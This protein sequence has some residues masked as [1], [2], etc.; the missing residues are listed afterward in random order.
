MPACGLNAHLNARRGNM[1][2]CRTVETMEEHQQPD[3]PEPFQNDR[4]DLVKTVM[5][6][7]AAAAGALLVVHAM[8]APG[9]SWWS[10]E[11]WTTP[12][13]GWV[14]HLL[15]YGTPVEVAIYAAAFSVVVAVIV[16][17]FTKT[18]AGFEMWL[19]SCLVVVCAMAARFAAT[20]GLENFD[21]QTG[22]WG[23]M[24]GSGL[25]D[26]VA[27]FWAGEGVSLTRFAVLTTGTL[28]F[29]LGA[30][31]TIVVLVGVKNM[32]RQ[33]RAESSDHPEKHR[34]STD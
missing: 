2:G 28:W 34:S 6:V 11:A 29:A 17:G 19:L 24:E 13:P 8:M 25:P 14:D 27:R 18:L 23:T 31:V 4:K 1:V 9:A 30:F 7:V 33:E 16:L 12:L 32:Q 15:A 3:S 20:F 21:T 26:T 22:T 10:A 5:A